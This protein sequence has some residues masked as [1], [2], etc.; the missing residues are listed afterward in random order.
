MA[1]SADMTFWINSLIFNRLANICPDLSLNGEDR[2]VYEICM[3]DFR[4][5]ANYLERNHP[6]VDE[7]LPIE[8]YPQTVMEEIVSFVI[9]NISGL[10]QTLRST[11]E[12]TEFINMWVKWWWRKWQERTKII[13]NEKD[14]PKSATVNI[15]TL[16]STFTPEEHKGVIVAVAD[17][18]IQYGEICCVF[19]MADALFI[20]A[21]EDANKKEWTLQDKLNLIS[22]LQRT[23]KEV[24]YTHGP[25]V[26]LRPDN[27]FKFR[28]WRSDGAN[29]II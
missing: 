10:P 26:F 20:K 11:Q 21:F 29:K 5:F 2:K 6:K 1:L 3:K 14:L 27:Y 18:L 22:K 19:I 7:G 28:E 8:D 17:K 4:D 12:I 25:L 9:D 15:S 24:A 13:L 16:A 23:A